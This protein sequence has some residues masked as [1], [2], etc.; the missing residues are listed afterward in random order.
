VAASALE[1][2]DVDDGLYAA[3]VRDGLVA[4]DGQRKCWATI[5]QDLEQLRQNGHS[6]RHVRCEGELTALEIGVA[7]SQNGAGLVQS[8][9]TPDLAARLEARGATRAS[10]S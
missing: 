4:D 5:V 7:Q 8:R 1:Q 9:V 2:A 6:C 10:F 3:A